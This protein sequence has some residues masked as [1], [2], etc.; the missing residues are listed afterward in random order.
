MECGTDEAGD[1]TAEIFTSAWAGTVAGFAAVGIAI[2]ETG[3]RIVR[4][5]PALEEM[6]GYS[7]GELPGRDL[8]ELFSMQDRSSLQHH[9]QQLLAEPVSR[10]R[11]PFRLRRK[12]G[13]N[14]PVY[15][16]V[17]LLHDAEQRSCYVATVVEDFSDQYLLTER[18]NHQAL[19][20]VATGLPNRQYLVSHL[21]RIL[22]VLDPS[23]VITLLHLDLD[24]FSAVNDALG[25]SVGD[26]LLDV[27]ARR[28]E[29]VVAG[30]RAMVARLGGDEF[31]VVVESGDAVPDV[32]SL[33]EAIN[34]ELAEPV[35]V[36]D[37]GTAVT[38]SIGV[39]QRSVANSEP[40]ELL[41][42]AGATLRRVRGQGSRQW[43]LFDAD[44]DAAQRVEL[45]LAAALPGALE[46]GELL[47]CYQPVV[48]LGEGRVVGVEAV[49]NWQHPELGVLPAQR[50]LQLAEQTGMVHAAGALL[51]HA[52][53][54]QAAVWQR[55]WGDLA[56]PM[57]VNLAAPQARDPDL[58]A[59]VRDVLRR[60]ELA[61]TALQL[62]VPAAALHAVDGLPAGPGSAEAE[63][64]LRVLAGLGIRTGLNDFG[65]GI[66]GLR[67]LAD[68]P[69]HAV[70]VAEPVSRQV[71]A[72]PSRILSQSVH[73]LIHI[74]RGE[75]FDVVAY[76]V[77]SEQEREC[78]RW[79]GA[80][81]AAGA[82]FGRAGP[83]QL[84][85]PLLEAQC[86]PEARS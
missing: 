67:C 61:P 37:V 81:W 43:A 86:T 36:D 41:R 83:P 69:V 18:L 11:M 40:D 35:Y 49:L 47:V 57:I 13:E 17:S 23:A 77:D 80:N 28:L 82:L 51:L 85:E 75:G 39:V 52:A 27:V 12:D 29:A 54:E 42:A 66:G 31:A 15:L 26:Q 53:A 14:A 1:G 71:A 45:R 5:N 6:L 16:A 38:A 3:G 56:P 48:T 4:A 70:R 76:P 8:G 32:G 50:C 74:V 10:F 78:W 34:S 22:G 72:D 19:H 44:V 62:W 25:H 21:E 64:N 59:T 58:V 9:Y 60:A 79:V 33:A 65:G 46:S 2:S 24:G 30:Q 7:D 63:D 55:Q 84:V 68:L 73:A 20:D